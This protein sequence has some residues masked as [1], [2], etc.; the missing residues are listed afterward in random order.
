MEQMIQDYLTD[1]E[2]GE[3]QK[4]ENLAVVPLL[5]ASEDG[6]EYM[7]LSEALEAETLKVTEISESGSVPELK[8]TN[9]S[10]L[11]V[12]MLD[13]EELVGAK[14][15]RV[16]NT[17][18]LVRDDSETVVPVSCTEQGRWHYRSPKFSDSGHVMTPSQRMRKSHSV[19]DSL[20]RTRQFRSDQNQV[21]RDVQ[22]MHRA[23]GT[24][25]PTGAMRDAYEQRQEDL[26]AYLKGIQRAEEQAGLLVFINGQVVGFDALSR[27][28][29]YAKLHGK[30]VR[31]Y[32]MEAL[33]KQNGE[34]EEV[35]P[36]MAQDFVDEARQC[37]EKKFES[38][39]YGMDYRYRGEAIIGSALVC[40]EWPVHCAF[41]RDESGG[42]EE[43]GHISPMGIR[44]H[45]RE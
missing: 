34:S 44:R 15:N 6:L 41:F 19:S 43:Q 26:E 27:S 42:D 37:D 28:E 40:D 16:L 30:L 22:H 25:S 9:E 18:I 35:G 38:V 11:P 8:V 5:S 12:L 39:G 31:S 21:W 29:T 36:E 1:L 4:V 7:T 23:S 13:G 3:M 20:E 24:D 2:F 17:T 45:F 33:L 14:Q 32:A 10:D